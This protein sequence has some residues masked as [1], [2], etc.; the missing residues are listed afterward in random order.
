MMLE[1]MVIGA[2]PA[3]IAAVGKLLDEGIPAQKIGWMDPY[4]TVGDLGRKWGE[5]PSNTQVQLFTRYLKNC[6]AFQYGTQPK[7][8]LLE[9]LDP[10]DTCE[11]KKVA[12][13]LQWITEHLKQ[14]VQT[15]LDVAM[16]LQLAGRC[17]EVKTKGKS[18]HAK[19]VIL[20]IGSD[21]KNL[22]Y[23]ELEVIPME[24]AL[25]PEKLVEHINAQD[26]VAVFGASHSA[27][28]VLANLLRLKPKQ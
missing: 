2:G 23:P 12:E 28:L 11:L 26:T 4:F 15:F 24:T 18:V 8:F 19:N 1:W 22:S 13:P 10:Q 17:W 16:A 5:V 25:A 14:K 7:K 3:G 6:K 21:P 27:V 9:S 20:A